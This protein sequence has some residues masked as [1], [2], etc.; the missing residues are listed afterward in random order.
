MQYYI[1]QRYRPPCTSCVS[2]FGVVTCIKHSTQK[3]ESRITVWLMSWFNW[4]QFIVQSKALRLFFQAAKFLLRLKRLDAVEI[5]RM[6]KISAVFWNT[7]MGWAFLNP[8]TQADIISRVLRN[9]SGKFH[10]MWKF[11]KAFSLP[12]SNVRKIVVIMA[13]GVRVESSTV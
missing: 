6:K 8:N 1:L 7:F 2:I 13:P 4:K 5:H 9:I 3:K 10:G 12:V 11:C